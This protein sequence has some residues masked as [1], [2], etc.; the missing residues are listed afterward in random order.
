M[1]ASVW[2]DSGDFISD[3]RKRLWSNFEGRF[4][5][6]SAAGGFRLVQRYLQKQVMS[7]LLYISVLWHIYDE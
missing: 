1:V 3:K 7:Y 2:R 4:D 6:K 5:Q